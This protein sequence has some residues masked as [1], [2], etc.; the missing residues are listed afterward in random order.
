MTIPYY[1]ELE[2]S[3]I[4]IEI[5]KLTDENKEIGVKS[6]VLK[7]KPAFFLPSGRL[8]YTTTNHYNANFYRQIIE[9]FEVIEMIKDRQKIVSFS[10]DNNE[11]YWRHHEERVPQA[12][13]KIH[14]DKIL[15]DDS[16]YFQFNSTIYELLCRHFN[17]KL[18]IPE[19][20]MESLYSRH[21]G[22]SDI[23]MS[24]ERNNLIQVIVNYTAMERLTNK[25]NLLLNG[26]NKILEDGIT[27][28][29]VQKYLNY[30]C[31]P[32]RKFHPDIKDIYNENCKEIVLSIIQSKLEVYNYF[33]ELVKRNQNPTEALLNYPDK[34]MEKYK[35]ILSE[36]INRYN[37][38]NEEIG[39]P[40]N[41]YYN[42]KLEFL[43]NYCFIQDFVVQAMNFDKIES[44]LQKTITTSK[45]NIYE[46][47]FN[48]LIMDFN[49]YQINSIRYNDNTGK[50]EVFDKNEFIQTGQ[51][52][53]LQREVELI[54][55]LVP[56]KDR[57]NYFI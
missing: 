4:D 2:K 30:N 13:F 55:K 14:K 34:L 56:Y 12:V 9:S 39:L 25:R 27:A 18:I 26:L 28:G 7:I 46:T 45:D 44:M 11:L 49:L 36:Q 41:G 33:I 3:R 5:A 15:I 32:F 47:F 6:T 57:R 17:K 43:K 50:F 38:R 24:E 40:I 29:D 20:T 22:Y 37:T 31:L 1:S 21:S 8:Y 42:G 23:Y 51:E 35:N 16:N 52:K 19:Y 10:Y 54:K 48:Y 53:E